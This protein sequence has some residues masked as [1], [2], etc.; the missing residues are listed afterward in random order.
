M[1]S[2]GWLPILKW[3]VYILAVVIL[4]LG[5]IAGFSLLSSSSAVQ[6]ALTPFQAIG[7]GAIVNLITPYLRSLLS[8]L[9]VMTLVISLAL[10][11]VL[12]AVGRLLGRNAGL[13]ARLARLEAVVLA[14]SPAPAN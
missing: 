11:L 6:N 1:G 10:S 5:L 12:F 9:G 13:E 14:G 2:N 8:S 7:G 4:G 3:T